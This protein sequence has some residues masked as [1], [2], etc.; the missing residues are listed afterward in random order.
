[1]RDSRGPDPV[2]LVAG[3]ELIALGG[4]L[5]AGALDVFTPTVALLAPATAAAVGVI[6]LV[7]GLQP[8]HERAPGGRAQL[9]R[10]TLHR[11]PDRRWIGGVCAGIAGT[12]GVEPIVVR[13][14][15]VIGAL[16]GGLGAVVYVIAWFALP[17][18][19]VEGLRPPATRGA[20]AVA[21]GV[22]LLALATLL[23]MR[24]LGVWF[25]DALVWPVALV[26]G[27]A[28]LLWRRS[29]TQP[30]ALAPEPREPEVVAEPES[31]GERIS[32][33]GVGT[34]LVVAAALVFLQTTGALGA[35]RDVVLAA[36]VVAA[37]LGV[38]FAP[39][40]VRLIRSRDTE[41]AERIRSQE[42]A[43]VAAHLHDSVLQTLALVQQRADDPR[44]V[45]QLA[46]R[47]ERE[48]RRWLAGETN[49]ATSLARALET[50]AE[51]VER[52]HRVDVD[53]VIV[54]DAQLDERTS[55]LLA[56]AREAMVNAARHGGG[57][58]VAVYAEARDGH[59]EIDVRDRGPGFDLATVPDE[60]RGVRESI[61]GRMERHGG[62]ASI[63]PAPGGGTE[64]E[65]TIPLAEYQP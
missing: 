23:A 6:L 45:A 29:R 24:G 36:L 64:V 40:I 21:L 14:A 42:R 11:D 53:V 8:Q 57:S 37:V 54:G 12:L 30:V 41:R 2:A 9:A 27:G 55:A 19:R 4:L 50:T 32:R 39:S 15:F 31:R 7:L 56:A 60:R 59:A 44:A 58:A 22:T 33:T 46:R 20:L 47:Q 49:G 26:A 13:V 65:L 48:L 52:D 1:M 25:G 3:I 63:G 16:A 28:A 35:V 17:A 18:R 43:E 10:G 62:R 34:A 61:I 5:L 51:D 38:V